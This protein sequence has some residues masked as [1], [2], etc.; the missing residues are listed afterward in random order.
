MKTGKP[1]KTIPGSFNDNRLLKVCSLLNQEGAKYLVIGGLALNLHGI[2][3]ATKDVDLLIPK[4]IKN[5]KKILKA[6]ERL[7]FGIA[8]ELEAEEV[9]Q[10]PFTIIG[11]NPRVDL[12][13]VAAKVKYEDAKKTALQTKIKKIKIPY[14]DYETLI[15][16][17][18]T[19]R[20]KDKADVEILKKLGKRKN[21]S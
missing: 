14:L 5:T 3:Q 10:K 13:T 17:K 18:S 6:L 21:R 7:S 9:I 16:T 2:I 8:K 20:L 19:G 15:K 4:D 11:D 12:V 1:N